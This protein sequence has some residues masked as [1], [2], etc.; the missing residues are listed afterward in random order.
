MLV[1]SCESSAYGK[2]TVEYRAQILM[3]YNDEVSL[4]QA[5]AHPD[6]P[7]RSSLDR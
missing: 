1:E 5:I 6:L 2:A 4:I 7:D 3:R